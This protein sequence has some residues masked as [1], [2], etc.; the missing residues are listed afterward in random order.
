M[1][2]NLNRMITRSRKRHLYAS[3]VSCVAIV[4]C[5]LVSP[6]LV[7]Q[8]ADAA[9]WP[10]L[11]GP[12]RDGVSAERLPNTLGKLKPKWEHQVGAGFAGPAVVDGNVIVFHRIDDEIVI[13]SLDAKSGKQRWEY[14]DAT[15]FTGGVNPDNGPRCV[16]V[17]ANGRVFAF[18]SDGDLHC[19]QLDSG[20]KIWK[21]RLKVD[22]RAPDG[23]FGA[24]AT[25]VAFG[26][27]VFICLGGRMGASVV[28]LNAETGE[29]L[30][31]KGNDRVSYASPVATKFAG[32]NQVLFLAELRLFS[33][34][35]ESGDEL[36]AVPF[37]KRGQTVT[38]CS[39][40]VFDNKVF[41]SAS[42]Y[43]GASML[44]LKT[45]KPKTIWGDDK[46]LSS[47]Y[48]NIVQSKGYLYGTHGRE[49]VGVAELRCVDASNGK[50]K[51]TKPGFGVCHMIMG[52]DKLLIHRVQEGELVLAE[53]TSKAFKELDR[54]QVTSDQLKAIPAMS[55]G[56]LFLRTNG[57][58]GKLLCLPLPKSE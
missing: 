55:G 40:L 9:D 43:I 31:T 26:D 36:W 8:T 51:W 48:T 24:G 22:Y 47:Q 54:V 39:P 16:P 41:L 4:A 53:A 21:R 23:F 11:L 20:K 52:G 50:V 56:S 28:A 1:V 17:V 49:D 30:W 57:G 19:V 37:G 27:R 32:K 35:P 18:G 5:T 58:G 7:S 44:D 2:S 14:R 38:A 10:Q 45:G 29:T 3:I 46:T 15:K 13:E 34:D 42:Y 33:L 12:N 6:T 25:P